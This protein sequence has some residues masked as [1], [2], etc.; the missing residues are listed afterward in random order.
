MS[1]QVERDRPAEEA[2]V[3]EEMFDRGERALMKVLG[4]TL[5]QPI[6]D[7]FIREAV[8]LIYREMM[9]ARKS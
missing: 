5:Q 9:A 3:T 8:G 7:R 1:R 6:P 2:E 4:Y